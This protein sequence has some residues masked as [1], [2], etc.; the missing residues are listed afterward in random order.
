MTPDYGVA[1]LAVATALVDELSLRGVRHV[2]LCPGSRST[3]LAVAFAAHRE[4]RH[5]VLIDERSAA[6][7]ALGMARQLNGSVALLC[8]SG[9]AA[10]NF[11]PAVIEAFLSRIP[12][13]VVTADRP[14]ELRDWGAAQT[15]HQNNL[16][17]AHVK[18]FADL[19][20][21]DGDTHLPAFARAA[22]SRAAVTA[23]AAPP[24]PVHLNLPFR[25]PLLPE[26]L[27][28]E[29]ISGAS[30][31]PLEARNQG[32]SPAPVGADTP[33]DEAARLISSLP[34]GI[35]VCGPLEER[36]AAAAVLQLAQTTGY[37]VLADPLS[38]LRFGELDRR[39][40]LDSYDLFLRD[41]E[42]RK[43][44]SPE[45]VIRCG[46]VPTS[47]PLNQ[48]LASAREALHLTIDPG[49]LRDPFH[50]SQRHLQGTIARTASSLAA[51][52]DGMT[53]AFEPSWLPL[54]RSAQEA[55]AGAIAAAIS[56]IAEPFEGRAIAELASLL[57]NG[58]TLVVGN[59]MPIRD[60][61]AYVRGDNRRICIVGN[62]GANGIDGL[63]SSAL[64]AAAVATSPVALVVGDLSFL[65]DLG[66]LLAA[67]RFNLALTIVVLNNNGG[68][69]FS[70]LPQRSQLD[71]QIFELLFGTPADINIA[72]A[73]ALFGGQY[74]APSS[75]ESFRSAVIGGLTGT[76]LTIIEVKTER[77]RNLELHRDIA[78]EVSAALERGSAHVA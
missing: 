23:S 65:H 11:S 64:G 34:R 49:S 36:H 28:L 46:A 21:P 73:S 53:M 50:L 30:V 69:I 7:F 4:F 41:A 37:P 76:G 13:I 68:G 16:Y 5:W 3:P 66:G 10:A 47:K 9:T 59:S 51:L 75:W 70:F 14:P 77:E 78:A 54:W 67:R 22:A 19:P 20:V 40:V 42:A 48:F 26:T 6:F 27:D 12:L 35:I 58:A 62:R 33:L 25:E 8:T 44:L 57:P 29:A 15:I 2:I 39:Y 31:A 71:S 72:E 74:H 24:G 45:V 61:D 17:G 60:V 52:L 18:W 43:D 56:G 55:T 38:T 63:T 32:Q 1:N